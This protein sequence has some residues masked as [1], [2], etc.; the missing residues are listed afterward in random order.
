MAVPS[1][2]MFGAVSD[3]VSLSPW[4]MATFRGSSQPGPITA[5]HVALRDVLGVAD[6]ADRGVHAV[7]EHALPSPPPRK[8]LQDASGCGSIIGALPSAPYRQCNPPGYTE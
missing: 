8:R 7:I 5:S 6:V 4:G 1:V 2:S 3:P